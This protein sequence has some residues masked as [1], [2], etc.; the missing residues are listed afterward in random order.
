MDDSASSVLCF[1]GFA[2]DAEN[3]QL[4]RGE[5]VVPLRPKTLAVLRCLAERPGRLVT[6]P[7]LLDAVWGQ[8]AVSEGVLTSCVKELRR[9]LAD[10]PRTPHIIET[11]HR[12]GYRFIA[13][14]QAGRGFGKEAATRPTP[15]T[16]AFVGRESELAEL[17]T[18][19]RCALGRERQVGFIAGEAGIGKTTLVDTFLSRLN[20]QHPGLLVARAHCLEHHGPTALAAEPYLPVLEALG[21]LRAAPEAPALLGLLRRYAP[22]WLGLLHGVLDSERA[23]APQAPAVATTRQRMLRELTAFVEAL[24]VP[25]VVVVEDL[26]WCDYATLDLV[27]A[28][29]QARAPAPLLLIGTY[30]P[31]DV[32][33]HKHPLK[34]VHQ[35][36]RAHGQ[37]RDLWLRHLDE[38]AVADYLRMRCPG[39]PSA[40]RLARVL[41][42]RTD[43]NPLFMVNVVDH[44][45]TA[46]AL[47]ETDG[48][49]ALA[50]HV[51]EVV[52]GASEGLR[53]LLTTQIEGL[54]HAEREVLEVGSVVGRTF[55]AA[56]VAAALD[57]DVVEVE[58]RVEHLARREQLVRAADESTWPDGTVAGR[59]RFIHSL[60]QDVLTTR[61]PPARRRQLH[62]RI[63]ARLEAGYGDQAAEVAARLASHFEAS[64]QTECA[65]PYLEES[66]ARAT[67][68]GTSR[69]AAALLAHGLSLLATLPRTPER[70]SQTARLCMALGMALQP[71]CGFAAKEVEDAFARAREL[72]AEIDDPALLFLG[73]VVLTGVYT[74]QARL[75]RAAQTAAQLVELMARLPV[76]PVPFVGHV[77]IGMVRFHSGSLSEA[78]THFEQALASVADSGSAGRRWVEPQADTSRIAIPLDL[79]VH[80]LSY[81]ASTLFQQGYPEQ[82]RQ[83]C[84]QAAERATTA[85]PFDRGNAASFACWVHMHL[86]D[87]ARLARAANEVVSLGEDYGFPLATAIGRF[88]QGQMLVASGDYD[89]G[90]AGMM[91]GI[92]VYRATRQL[93]SV[94]GLLTVLAGSQAQAGQIAG[95]LESVA[96]ARAL[97][98][99]A[100]EVRFEAEIHRLEGELQLARSEIVAAERSLRRAIEIAQEQGA[101]WWELRASVSLARLLRHRRKRTAARDVLEP[102]TRSFT[103]GL[104]TSDVQA[105]HALLGELS[106]RG[107][108]RGQA[109]FQSPRG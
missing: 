43:G 90:I 105:A 78:R 44:L 91:E 18:W 23:P 106:A 37:C 57:Q 51:A 67:K 8:A 10:D 96:E 77:F 92:A 54:P 93:V 17:D 59:Y 12:H 24:P 101:R 94:P 107:R 3:A 99:G 45:V 31:V 56:L 48:H 19:L 102:I 4:R 95:A 103:E 97:A 53:Q 62:A 79:R 2:L 61:V 64:G 108:K 6:R 86:R 69:E 1:V 73:V 84:E 13:E 72:S 16:L 71:H 35:E 29:A 11:A 65:I 58:D 49:W 34:S 98:A 81:L 60:Y 28:L 80:T 20:T 46:G 32:A 39:L 85:G 66:A 82:A 26:H 75:D 21:R 109:T 33:V 104:D 89:S 30:R 88:A 36:L 40:D 9:A 27:A 42:E 76:P 68:M 22:S 41:H 15:S 52:P 47:V 50:V 14:I 74:V 38:D 5:R 70:T 25:L 63:A 7:E 83:R 100:G 55:S 87:A